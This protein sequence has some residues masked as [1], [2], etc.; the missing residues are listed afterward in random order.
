MENNKEDE[1]QNKDENVKTQSQEKA[2]EKAEKENEKAEKKE[3]DANANSDSKAKEKAEAE[4][5]EKTKLADE[6]KDKWIRVSAE[7]ENY[8]KRTARDSFTSYMEGKADI[9]K[10]ILPIGDNLERAIETTTD[11]KIKEGILLVIRNYSKILEAENVKEINPEGEPFDHTTCEAIMSM[12]AAEGEK[13]GI[14]KKVLVKGYKLDDKVIRYAQVA[15]TAKN[16]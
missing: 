12:P 3:K 10:K 16:N 1:K 9:L 2:Q 8:R 11:E 6:Y 15:V 4:L 13:E 7:F 5:L 14:I